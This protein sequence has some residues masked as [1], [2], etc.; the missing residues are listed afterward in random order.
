MKNVHFYVWKLN[1]SSAL[2]VNAV[3]V[4]GLGLFHLPVQL[5]PTHIGPVVQICLEALTRN[6]NPVDGQIGVLVIKG[7]RDVWIS[8][9]AGDRAFTAGLRDHAVGA[10]NEPHLRV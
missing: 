7:D 8:D 9:H 3:D 10:F 6:I 1:I 5:C 4:E 2:T